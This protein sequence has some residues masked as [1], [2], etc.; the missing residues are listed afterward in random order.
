MK[1]R[2]LFL[3]C[4]LFCGLDF[5]ARAQAQLPY[6]TAATFYISVDDWADLWLNGIPVIDSQPYTGAEKGPQRRNCLPEHLCYFQKNNILAIEVADAVKK[7]EPLEDFAGIAYSLELDFSD[8]THRILT[9][10]EVD[11]HRSYYLPDRMAGTP[12]GWHKLIF[13]DDG[14]E[15]A[16]GNP[17]GIVGL[18]VVSHPGNGNTLPFLSASS[19]YSKGQ[20]MGERHLFRREFSLDIAPHPNCPTPT[21]DF[22]QKPRPPNRLTIQRRNVT[23]ALWTA[24]PVLA[25]AAIVVPTFQG[26]APSSQTSAAVMPTSP[27]TAA[28]PL[29]STP[30]PESSLSRETDKGVLP[31][32]TRFVSETPTPLTTLYPVP[33]PAATPVENEN[34]GNVYMSFADGP[35]IYRL[36]IFDK[37]G[38]HM[39]YLFEQKVVA[40][41]GNWAEWD[42]LDDRGGA[43]PPG[44]YYGDFSKDGKSLK[45]ILIKHG[46]SEGEQD[47]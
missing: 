19:F 46:G 33:P 35:G 43:V 47:Q 45:R 8:G 2:L 18:A 44:S 32:S 42:G 23:T 11:Q 29:E 24:T 1:Q 37:A 38:R 30:A 41:E 21:A 17:A 9:S 20:R 4:F 34:Y 13:N 40:E 10:A 39:R 5:S 27:V 31:A 7:R 3:L 14:W 36:E 25:P 6:L 26:P 12:P 15:K 16:K 22:F 28:K